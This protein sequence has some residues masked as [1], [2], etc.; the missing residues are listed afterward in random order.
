M[1]NNMDN[2]KQFLEKHPIDCGEEEDLMGLIYSVIT[3]NNRVED[4]NIRRQFAGL[5]EK[6]EDLLGGKFDQLFDD[7][8]ALCVCH[9]RQAFDA[10]FR[11]GA[12]LILEVTEM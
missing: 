10:G 2:M 9:E 11:T 5:R 6:Y 1:N 3:E 12:Q 7:V 4:D 8:C